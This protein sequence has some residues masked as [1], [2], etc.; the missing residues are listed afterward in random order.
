MKKIASLF[1]IC[2]LFATAAIAG[3]NQP[4]GGKTVKFTLNYSFKGIVEGYDHDNKTELYIDGILVATSSVKKETEKNSITVDI[5]KGSHDI[6]VINY[7]YYE[8]TWEEHTIAN[9]Y[10]ID[11]LYETKMNITKK[12]NKLNLLFDIDSGTQVVK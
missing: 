9:N 3:N 5:T 12:K 10:S 8:G 6:K 2:T 4:S 1:L 11:C 7:A